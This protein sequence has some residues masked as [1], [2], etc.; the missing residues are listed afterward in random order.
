MDKSDFH[1]FLVCLRNQRPVLAP[2]TVHNRCSI[3]RGFL[4]ANDINVIARQDL[5]RYTEK[6]VAAYSED[7]LKALFAAA[8]TEDR[9]AFQ[10]FLLTGVREQEVQ[11]AC[12]SDVDGI[13]AHA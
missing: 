8:I 10:F 7:E 12:W 9:L 3:L 4:R 1:E 11:F 2:R 13:R 5:P 6:E